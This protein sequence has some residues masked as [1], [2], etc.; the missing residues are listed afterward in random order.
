MREKNERRYV[1]LPF[2]EIFLPI[3][4]PM[5]VFDEHSVSKK[6]KSLIIVRL[7]FN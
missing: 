4:Q 6:W 7:F 3:D 1:C 5:K 2:R